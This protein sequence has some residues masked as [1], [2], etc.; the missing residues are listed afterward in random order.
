MSIT[1]CE[2]YNKHKLYQTISLADTEAYL[3][4]ALPQR[5]AEI[6]WEWRKGKWLQ[7]NGEYTP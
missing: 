2:W 6:T 1:M 5:T 7:E 3:L 4:P